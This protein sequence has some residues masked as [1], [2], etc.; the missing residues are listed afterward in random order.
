[1]KKKNKRNYIY[2]YKNFTSKEFPQVSLASAKHFSK[3]A[4]RPSSLSQIPFFVEKVFIY[5][6]L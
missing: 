4:A 2:L 6:S 1:L 3:Y 5:E